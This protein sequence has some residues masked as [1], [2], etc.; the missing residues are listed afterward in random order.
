[1]LAD[2][3]RKT[4]L[5]FQVGVWVSH[6]LPFI[7]TTREKRTRVLCDKAAKLGIYRLKYRIFATFLK[8]AFISYSLNSKTHR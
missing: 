5:M 8:W 1:M 7:W 6:A 3:V 4:S 2:D